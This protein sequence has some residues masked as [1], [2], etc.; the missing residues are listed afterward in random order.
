MPTEE[1]LRDVLARQEAVNAASGHASLS[2]FSFFTVIIYLMVTLASINHQTLF[3][4]S[5]INLPALRVELPIFAFFISTPLLIVAFHFYLLMQLLMLRLKANAFNEALERDVRLMVDRVAIRNGCELFPVT[6]LLAGPARECCDI[7][8]YLLR[9]VAAISLQLAPLAV[10]VQCL[11]TFLPYHNEAVTWVHRGAILLDLPLILAIGHAYRLAELNSLRGFATALVSSAIALAVSLFSIFV[12]SYPGEWAHQSGIAA[13]AEALG[14]I[15][16]KSNELTGR[17]TALFPNALILMGA[18]PF[19]SSDG[20]PIARRSFRG[21]NLRSANFAR[22]ELDGVDFSGANLNDASFYQAKLRYST[23]SCIATSEISR[24][25]GRF[26]V[27]DLRPASVGRWPEG[28][29]AWLQGANFQ[30]ADLAGAWL[31]GAQLHGANFAM[32][33]LQ[34]ASFKAA[35]LDAASFLA[36]QLEGAS[37]SGARLNGAA[38]NGAKLQ[39]A[40]ISG[41]DL[42]GV[43]LGF[44]FVLLSRNECTKGCRTMLV[45][46]TSVWR[47]K[48]IPSTMSLASLETIDVATKP[49]KLGGYKQWRDDLTVTAKSAET[50]A[51]IKNAILALNPDLASPAD[52]LS[53]ADWK[54]LEALSQKE[55]VAESDALSFFVEMACSPDNAPYVARGL[56]RNGRVEAIGLKLAEFISVLKD[57]T[58]CSGAVALNDVDFKL[59]NTIADA[60]QGELAKERHLS[61]G[62]RPPVAIDVLRNQPPKE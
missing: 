61:P 31:D 49:F 52:S 47:V 25:P 43:A 7:H 15:G 33:K 23:L 36:A 21:R 51:R 1:Q 2:W 17:G 34:G 62:E 35:F 56:I 3:M 27:V 59:L 9:V 44:T 24:Q 39:G 45:P 16:S 48:G 20:K 58:R 14:V 37:F 57:S 46:K 18:N 30:E 50:S 40:D 19:V 54:K 8:R 55:P 6:Q 42:S 29:C 53:A 13:R 32:A 41:A 60:R 10:L 22:A 28:G 12:A 4:E 38:L 11:L 26:Q 5:P